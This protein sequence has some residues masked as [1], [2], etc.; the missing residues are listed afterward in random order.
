VR[1]SFGLVGDLTCRRADARQLDAWVFERVEALL[2]Q[3]ANNA[4][5]RSELGAPG[6]VFFLHLLG[7]DTTGHAYRPHSREYLAGIRYVDDGVRRLAA[8]AETVFADQGLDTPARREP[9]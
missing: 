9:L 4:T 5:L 7:L 8:L 6:T 3:A 2:I 1:A